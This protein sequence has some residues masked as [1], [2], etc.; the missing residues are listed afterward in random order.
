MV[1]TPYNDEKEEEENDLTLL[2]HTPS[3]AT[4]DDYGVAHCAP[5]DVVVGRRR[6]RRRRREREREE[7]RRWRWKWRRFRLPW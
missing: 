2:L 4:S 3:F 5:L 6:R 1:G 7:E